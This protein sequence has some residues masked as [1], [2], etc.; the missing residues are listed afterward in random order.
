MIADSSALL[1]VL[2]KEESGEKILDCIIKSETISIGAPTL[3]ES[4]IVFTSRTGLSESILADFTT[5]AGISII[6]FSDEHWREAVF[7][8]E[9]FGKGR[10]L[11][12]L[13]FGDCLSYALARVF[14]QPLLRTGH[15]FERTD[16]ELVKY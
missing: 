5:S 1:A 12:C 14:G 9:K 4:G 10:H 11:A 2:F 15:D 13:N 16:I 7:A 3:V 8:Y 6:P